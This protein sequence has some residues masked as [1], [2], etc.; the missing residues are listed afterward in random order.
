MVAAAFLASLLL[1]PSAVSAQ[2]DSDGETGP[3]T[4]G[5]THR[6][7]TGESS[8]DE[9]VSC[10]DVVQVPEPGTLPLLAI[11]LAATWLARRKAK[12]TT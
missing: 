3:G 11:G 7:V 2:E 5:G 9:F 6:C 12:Q 8:D 10:D 1:G 4:G